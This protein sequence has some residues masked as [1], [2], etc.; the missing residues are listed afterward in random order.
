MS[1][2]TNKT[3]QT[4]I[5]TGGATGLGYAVAEQFLQQGDN[6]VLN[7][8][9]ETKLTQAAQQLGETDRIVIVVGDIIRVNGKTVTGKYMCRGTEFFTTALPSN[10]TDP[11]AATFVAQRF[12]VDGMG[13]LTGEGSEGDGTL[14]G[15]DLLVTAGSGVFAGATGTYAAIAGG[16]APFGKGRL[17]FEFL[18]D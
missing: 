17:T 18:L 15:D 13:T 2:T 9:T 7:G 14:G 4:V 12:R 1:P 11:D 6:V 10:H 8:R 3:P 5:I 16:P